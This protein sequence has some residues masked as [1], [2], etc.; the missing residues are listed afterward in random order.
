MKD[1]NYYDTFIE[2]AA[3][4]PVS[5][6]EVPS[7][8]GHEPSVPALQYDLIANNPYRYTQEDVLFTVHA[9]RKSIPRAEW[10]AEREK[11]FSKGQACLRSSS[12]GKRYGWGIHCDSEGRVALFAVESKEYKAFAKSDRVKHLRALRSKRA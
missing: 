1:A 12:L 10:P 5:T 4:C 7:S 9:T 6:A 11:F 3:D 8:R 2:V